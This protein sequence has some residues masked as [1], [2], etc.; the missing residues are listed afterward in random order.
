M[1]KKKIV[2][3]DVIN[4]HRRLLYSV[5]TSRDY[6]PLGWDADGENDTLRPHP[7]P[8]KVGTTVWVSGSGKW[9]PAIVVRSP[10]SRTPKVKVIHSAPSN[11]HRVYIKDVLPEDIRLKKVVH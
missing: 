5:T 6:A 2:I 9:R 10:W 11:P 3:A 4:T 1:A 7:G 8:F